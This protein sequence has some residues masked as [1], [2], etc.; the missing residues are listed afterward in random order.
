MIV[1][2][3]DDRPML[4]HVVDV[5]CDK[6]HMEKDEYTEEDRETV[7]KLN[8]TSEK[9]TTTLLITGDDVSQGEAYDMFAK[10][11]DA[12]LRNW[13]PGASQRLLYRAGAV[14]GIAQPNPQYG[15]AD[16][17]PA[18]SDHALIATWVVGRYVYRCSSCFRLF[19]LFDGK[20]DAS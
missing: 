6:M 13:V 19:D 10:I 5:I 18:T 9:T 14:L 12:E 20:R 7:R 4:H 11:V 17:G 8:E 16:C 15:T 2:N 3:D 1:F